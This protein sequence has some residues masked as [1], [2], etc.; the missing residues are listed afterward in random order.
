MGGASESESPQG[1]ISPL[2]IGADNYYAAEFDE[3]E[4][5]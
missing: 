3:E 2:S 4:G 1:S 5:R